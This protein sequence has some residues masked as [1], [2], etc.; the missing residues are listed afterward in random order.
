MNDAIAERLVQ[1]IKY[2]GTAVLGDTASLRRL[3][4]PGQAEPPPEVAALVFVLE[5]KAVEFLQKWARHD[6]GN[7]PSYEQVRDHVAGK[8]A[9]AGALTAEQGAWALDAWKRALNLE[10]AAPRAMTLEEVA[11]PPPPPAPPAPSEQPVPGLS[12]PRPGMQRPG[13]AGAGAPPAP[14]RASLLAPMGSAAAAPA[15]GANPYAP[16]Q[17]YVDDVVEPTEEGAFVEGGRTRPAGQGWQWIVRGWQLF[18]AAPATWVVTLIV[19]FVVSVVIQIVPVIGAIAGL[20]LGPVLFAGLML[21]AH[22]VDRGEALTLGHLFAG[23][24][25]RVGA[26]MLVGVLFFLMMAG[27]GVVLAVIFGASVFALFENPAAMANSFGLVLGALAVGALLLM[28]V[29]MAYYFSPALV[30]ISGR[31]PLDALK[32]SFSAC[33]RN[34]LSGLVY[35]LAFI[36]LAIAATIPFGLGWIVLAPVATASIYAAFRDIFY[37]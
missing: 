34:V 9:A 26:L 4:A 25:E 28:P 35:F 24:R 2:N 21:G 7:K 12:N 1:V 27:I 20:L 8:M 5:S 10:V 32:Q 6:T 30:S 29:S 22:A 19:F 37:E 23:F 16:P 15:D 31:R 13:A 11:P 14:Q 36:V 18:K 17:A 3:L 33:L